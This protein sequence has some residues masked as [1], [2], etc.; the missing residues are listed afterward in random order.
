MTYLSSPHVGS[1]NFSHSNFS[2]LT[3][4]LLPNVL[5]KFLDILI[6]YDSVANTI[7]LKKKANYELHVV[8]I[9]I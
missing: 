2:N 3:S 6:I 4:L 7:V 1:C 8:A 5:G 9:V